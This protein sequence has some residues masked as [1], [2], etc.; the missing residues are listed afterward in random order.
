[1]P[2]ENPDMNWY[3][4][5]QR[6]FKIV[7][8]LLVWIMVFLAC[9]RIH[10]GELKKVNF[11]PMWLPQPQF[12]GFYMAREKGFYEK[13]GLDVTILERGYNEDVLTDLVQGKS[14]F[15]IMNLLTAIEKRASGEDIVNVGQVFQRSAIEFV[16]R[17]TSGIN[18]PR[19]FNGKKIA[20]WRTVLRAQ[21]LGF[22]KTQ[23][24]TAKTFSVDEGISFF[25]KGAVDIIP[26]MHYNGYNTLINHGIDA[27]ELTVFRFKDFDMD[28]PEDGIYCLARTYK[29]DPELVQR[30]V[31]ASMEGWQ[32][33]VTHPDETVALMEKIRLAESLI[34]N[35]VH[36]QWMMK[37][38]PEM[39]RP[40]R[41]DSPDAHLVKSDF[42]KAVNF[43]I[44]TRT[45][46]RRV[47]YDEFYVTH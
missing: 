9:S 21:T 27:E 22:L 40:K 37:V 36:L 25:L 44:K 24:I 42:E 39:I 47:S 10:A 2:M 20:V 7:M 17:K 14:H 11:M 31:N 19:D 46:S 32:Y 6:G 38:M 15:G 18:T 28:F 45:I 29:A 26:V 13:C 1:M 16:A 8:G 33:A 5:T 35:P 34:T 43:L 30:F 3:P 12:A 23:N 41:P 4:G